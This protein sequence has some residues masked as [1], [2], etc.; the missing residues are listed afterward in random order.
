[1]LGKQLALQGIHIDTATWDVIE[2]ELSDTDLTDMAGNAFNTLSVGAVQ[3]VLLVVLAKMHA[4]WS[5]LPQEPSGA[6]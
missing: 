4:R 2:Q 1:M 5:L 6:S 3:L